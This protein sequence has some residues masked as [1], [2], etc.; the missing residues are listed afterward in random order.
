VPFSSK[1]CVKKLPKNVN[2]LTTPTL[3]TKAQKEAF[4]LI[5]PRTRY[6]DRNIRIKFIYSE[7]ATKGDQQ[8]EIFKALKMGASYSF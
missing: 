5:P 4:T 6:F 3:N 1:V 7:K 8:S 2:F